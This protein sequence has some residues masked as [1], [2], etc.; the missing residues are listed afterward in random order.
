MTWNR[1][2]TARKSP[3]RPGWLALV[4]WLCGATMLVSAP[5]WSDDFDRDD[6][7][8]GQCSATARAAF[9]A[10]NYEIKDDFW[11]AVGNCKNQE[12]PKEQRECKSEARELLRESRDECWEQYQARAD[13]CDALG[14]APYQPEINPDD[15]VETIDNP[16]LPLL[17]GSRWVYEGGDERI[18]VEVTDE[19]KEILGVTCTVVRDTV[20]EDGEVIEDTFDWFAQDREGHVWYF[21]ELSQEFE[22]GELVSLEGSWKAGKDDAQP[23]ILMLAH[24]QVGDIYRQE[25]FLGDAED[26][27]EVVELAEEVTIGLGDFVTLVTAEWTP[28]EPEVLE[29]KFY[30]PGI[31]P[32]LEVNPETGER[33]ELVEYR[34]GGDD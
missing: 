1:S 5:A 26:M 20:Y 28:L 19:T 29:N 3:C 27:A 12:D 7:Y 4:G 22:D 16:Y 23:G 6:G 21:G 30:A 14:E 2:I 9:K 11:I 34:I 25:F 32:I 33:I 24:P 8:R 10:C 31:G 15:F 17:P 18:V 13:I